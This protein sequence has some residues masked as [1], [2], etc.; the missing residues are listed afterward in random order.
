M[1]KRSTVFVCEAEP[2]G[3]AGVNAFLEAAG[4]FVIVGS[5]SSIGQAVGEI[6]AV[7]PELLLAD[8]YGA[9]RSATQAL[10]DLA[11]VSQITK[12]LLW[13]R[14]VP[15]AELVRA[16]HAGARGYVPKTSSLM[17][18]AEGLSCIAA[19]EV[20][21]DASASPALRQWSESRVLPRLTPRERQIFEFV[22][23]GRKNR[24]IAE[25]LA[26]TPGTVK[27]HLMH[28]FEKMGSRD[29]FELAMQGRRLLGE[30]HARGGIGSDT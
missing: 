20:Y 13:T 12:C 22:V 15:D 9:G 2:A 16:L 7:R 3:L 24:E 18:V 8:H 11:L 30:S 1:S 28:I 17:I 14:N 5:A 29:R 19:G 10:T 4:R 25:Q 21:F 6:D 23:E 26:I 27:V